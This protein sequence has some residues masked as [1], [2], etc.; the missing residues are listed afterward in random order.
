MVP[1][2]PNTCH[3]WC[4]EHGPR[5]TW[6]MDCRVDA[7]RGGH[8]TVPARFLSK[9]GLAVQLQ[10]VWS[11]DTLAS[12]AQCPLPGSHALPRAAFTWCVAKKEGLIGPCYSRPCW[13]T[14]LRT[15]VPGSYPPRLVREE[16]ELVYPA[17]AE[18]NTTTP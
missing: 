12:A 8:G 1:E 10:G 4:P 2:L 13:T 7:S 18:P 16:K 6:L 15:L 14:L 3:R 17:P 9:E 11:A 5:Q